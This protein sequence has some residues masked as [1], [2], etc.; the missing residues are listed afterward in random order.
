MGI[1]PKNNPKNKKAF[2]DFHKRQ[3]E[4]A[5]KTQFEARR[6]KIQG[7]LE[8]WESKMPNKYKLAQPS[9]LSKDTIKK[10]AQAPLRP[11]FDKQIVIQ[12]KDA[13]VSLFVAYAIVHGLL[14]NGVITPSEVRKTSLLDGYNNINGIYQ[15]RNWKDNFF[16]KRAKVLIIEGASKSV[17]NLAQKGE[18]QFWKE[19]EDFTKNKEVLVIITYLKNKEESEKELFVPT[20]SNDNK[21]NFELIKKSIYVPITDTEENEI[22]TKQRNAY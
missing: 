12:G 3:L 20:L 15:S 16:N 19:I 17:A 2:L 8:L 13:S 18:E 9:S 4:L 6:V 1:Q 10:I 5:K 22:E 7:N 14:Q 11:P 21:M